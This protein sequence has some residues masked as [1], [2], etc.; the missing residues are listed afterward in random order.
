MAAISLTEDQWR[1]VMAPTITHVLPK[2]GIACNFPQAVLYAPQKLQGRGLTTPYLN[3]YIQKIH[4]L[5]Q[6]TNAKTLTGELMSLELEQLRLEIGL[7]GRI[8]QAPYNKLV[9]A[10]TTGW[11]KTLW[12]FM[13]QHKIELDDPLPQIQPQRVNDICIMTLALATYKLPNQIQKINNCQKFLQ[14]TY[15]NDIVTVKGDRVISQSFHL[16]KS[17]ITSAP[18]RYN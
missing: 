14:V 10:T 2:S 1:Y 11:M 4:A 6:Q 8:T 13:A 5:L 9:L 12:R 17:F 18:T 15:L 7:P 3:N 16:S